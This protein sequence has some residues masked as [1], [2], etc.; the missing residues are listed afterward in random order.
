MA[1]D[2]A[3]TAETLKDV[4][5]LLAILMAAYAGFRLATGSEIEQ[6]G[7][8]KEVLAG[9]CIGLVLLYLAPLVAS[10]FIGG[11]VCT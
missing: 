2:I 10:Q 9:I 3:A 11:S 7:E 4:S 1:F 5:V 8:W 6:R